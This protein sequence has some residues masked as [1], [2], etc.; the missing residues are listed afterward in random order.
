MVKWADDIL[1]IFCTALF[2]HNRLLQRH[3]ITII[4][5]IIITIQYNNNTYFYRF[6]K[7]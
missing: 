5:R 7:Q 4:E 6:V 3:N 2:L 1:N